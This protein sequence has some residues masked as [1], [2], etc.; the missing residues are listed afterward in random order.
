MSVSR[1]APIVRPSI[2]LVASLVAACTAGPPAPA[3]ADPAAKFEAPAPAPAAKISPPPLTEQRREQI[4]ASRTASVAGL[5]RGPEGAALAGATVCARASSRHLAT[6]ETR[7]IPCTTSG[8]DGRY[9]ITGL[10][11]VRHRVGASAPNLAPADHDPP[12]SPGWIDLAAAEQRSGVDIDLLPG[13]T[14]Y[15]GR[16][17]D[18]KKRPL[19]NTQ[20]SFE[21]PGQ[22]PGVGAVT[23]TDA[24]GVYS[25]WLSTTRQGKMRFSHPGSADGTDAG[26]DVLYLHPEGRV[27][28]TITDK[29]GPVAGARVILEGEEPGRD[30]R[31][32][33]TDA[34]GR[35]DAD[36]LPEPLTWAKYRIVV[37]AGDAVASEEP[38]DVPHNEITTKDL[39]L[40][41][42]V[43]LRGHVVDE[44]G[45]PCP[46]GFVELGRV[47]AAPLRVAFAADGAFAVHET[48]DPPYALTARCPGFASL[49]AAP[50]PADASKAPLQLRV[51]RGRS[52][53]GRVL[54]SQGTPAGLVSISAVP[55]APDAAQQTQQTMS[56]RDGT[57]VLAGLN[58]GPHDLRVDSVYNSWETAPA[59]GPLR[60]EVPAD[61]DIDGIDLHLVHGTNPNP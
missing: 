51:S 55:V 13:G 37:T 17:V 42:A 54:T 29:D 56:E 25:M 21:P 19:A 30:S 7:D 14:L 23:H 15:T 12:G 32:A 58:P 2:L 48:G 47:Y 52:V 50:L 61:R 53:R 9:Q 16:V 18:P 39:V 33:F 24:K 10:Y 57:F 28:G 6:T 35:Y 1:A 45:A 20:V 46:A 27:Q 60:V 43:P 34:Q 11:G 44:T 5:V 59:K 49:A 36:R 26:S 41:P 22:W 4:V 38:F 3:A 40:S 8:A 31:I